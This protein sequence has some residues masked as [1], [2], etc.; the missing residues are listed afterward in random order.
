MDDNPTGF[1]KNWAS[2]K[3]AVLNAG[4]DFTL[5]LRRAEN[6]IDYHTCN[7][8][9]FRHLPDKSSPNAIQKATKSYESVKTFSGLKITNLSDA[10]N[11]SLLPTLNESFSFLWSTCERLSRRFNVWDLPKD[12]R[13][14]TPF[15][16][17]LWDGKDS[18]DSYRQLVHT[19]ARAAYY[20]QPAQQMPSDLS[21]TGNRSERIVACAV[22]WIASG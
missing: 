12:K 17:V 20:N 22:N 21:K 2:L 14:C 4:N 19:P 1:A 15:S 8:L 10:K 6:Q 3:S 7:S 11:C 5:L 16:V 13:H 9:I 18:P